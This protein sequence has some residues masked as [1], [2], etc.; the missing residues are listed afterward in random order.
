MNWLF[1]LVFACLGTVL[2]LGVLDIF[3][4]EK[5]QQQTEKLD[6]LS[7]DF[8]RQ[9][10]TVT[11]GYQGFGALRT[12]GLADHHIKQQVQKRV[13]ENSDQTIEHLEVIRDMFLA[14]GAYAIDSMGMIVAQQS[15]KG[16]GR[17]GYRVDFRPYFKQAIQGSISI[18][19]AV[20]SKSN[21]RGIYYAAPIYQTTSH[22]SAVLGVVMIKQ[23]VGFIDSLLKSY[24]RGEAFLLSPQGIVFSAT[25]LQYLYHLSSEVTPEQV[26]AI[27]KLKQFGNYFDKNKIAYLPF[28]WAPNPNLQAEQSHAFTQS[29]LW[30]EQM[31]LAKSQTVDL[32]DVNGAWHLLM[33]EPQGQ[34][35]SAKARAI[36]LAIAFVIFGLLGWLATWQYQQFRQ[37]K[38]VRHRLSMLS[39]AI[40]NSPTGVMMTDSQQNIRWVNAAL[41]RITGYSAD[42]L[43]GKKPS[44]LSSDLT[45]VDIRKDLKNSLRSGQTWRGQLVDRRQDDSAFWADLTISP[46][47]DD[48]K[49]L[50]GYVSLMQDETEKHFAA[51]K[52]ESE[53]RL[54]DANARFLSAIKSSESPFSLAELALAEIMLFLEVPLASIYSILPNDGLQ[55]LSNVGAQSASHLLSSDKQMLIQKIMTKEV[56]VDVHNPWSVESA[57]LSEQ[58]ASLKSALL[59]PIAYGESSCGVLELGLSDPLNDEQREYL[60]NVIREL[61]IALRFS[62]DLLVRKQVEELAIETEL[63]MRLLIEA[64]DDGILGVDEQGMITFANP[65]A[66][67]LLGY[68]SVEVLI[69][70]QVADALFGKDTQAMLEVGVTHALVY[71]EKRTAQITLARQSGEKFV[72]EIES[73]PMKTDKGW[74]GIVIVFKDISEKQRI[75]QQIEAQMEE[76]TR[77]T[78]VAVGRELKMIELKQQINALLVA[79]GKEALYDI[80]E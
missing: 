2:T 68:E 43:I 24:Q 64:V 48:Q 37:Q 75:Q 73:I 62:I 7:E 9:L 36:I 20:G 77:F 26:D 78:D 57:H 42:R 49:S 53:L 5:D 70:K 14:Q 17:T 45:D 3:Q 61:S 60:K 58:H 8:G 72:A 23:G 69:G 10:E 1:S 6:Q 80:A 19:P 16:K 40:V 35:V 52:L 47:F 54:V 44:V 76:L 59:L 15:I 33:L 21:T 12:L 32:A 67:T 63:R 66:T 41:E 65:A 18:Y 31:Y 74:D 71:G 56:P 30:G 27:K 25:N 29:I 38:E 28:S 55:V 39:S 51:L 11:L 50:T 79:S 4:T 13:P 46:V 22:T 34:F